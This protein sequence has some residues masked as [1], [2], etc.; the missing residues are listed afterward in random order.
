MAKL[1]QLLRVSFST[2]DAT[3]ALKAAVP[4]MR[5]GFNVSTHRGN[6]SVNGD[7][8]RALGELLEE[9]IRHRLASRKRANKASPASSGPPADQPG[10]T[11]VR[12]TSGLPQ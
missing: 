12:S 7:D 4:A 8:A 5:S 6:M 11:Y 10:L 2:K 1:Q 3:Q 9:R